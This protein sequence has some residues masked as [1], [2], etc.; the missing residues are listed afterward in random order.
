MVI[1]VKL[2][3]LGIAGL[4]FA[5]FASPDFTQKIFEFFKVGK[6]IY[7][8]GVLRVAIGL[9]L[10]FSVSHSTVPLAVISLGLLFLVSGIVIFAA[11][12]EKI[13]AFIAHYSELPQ[14]IIRM[15]GLVAACFGLL[16]FSVL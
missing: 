9:L 16:I 3:G 14:F 11:D 1:L 13:K 6:R 2:I 8:A 4:G 7:Y 10:L 12:P 15:L 5:I